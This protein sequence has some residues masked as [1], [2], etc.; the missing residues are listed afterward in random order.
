MGRLREVLDLNNILPKGADGEDS[1]ALCKRKYS[2]V[3][4][5]V[6][7]DPLLRAATARL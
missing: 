3:K 4:S 6:S 5:V 2:S 1:A 7:V